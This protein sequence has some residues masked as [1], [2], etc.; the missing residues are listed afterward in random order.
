[1]LGAWTRSTQ[2]VEEL[3]FELKAKY[4]IVIGDHNMQQGRG[5]S[6]VTVDFFYKGDLVEFGALEGADLHPRPAHE[7]TEAYY[8]EIRMS[9][10]SA[11][12]FHEELARSRSGSDHERGGGGGA[13]HRRRGPARAQ[14]GEARRVIAGDRIIDGM[15]AR[16]R[17]R[18]STF[19]PS[20]SRWRKISAL[21]GRQIAPVAGAASAAADWPVTSGLARPAVGRSDAATPEILRHRLL[22]G[23]KVDAR[24]LDLDLHPVDDSGRRR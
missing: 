21:V 5:V 19:S 3:I 24:L 16:S 20:S 13:R 7:Q 6:D 2:R 15:E 1:V 10:G 23:E 9:P 8:G 12:A 22:E 18:A 14:S 17:R 11:P 4:T